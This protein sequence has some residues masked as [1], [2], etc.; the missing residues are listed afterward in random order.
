MAVARDEGVLVAYLQGRVWLCAASRT[1][2]LVK[3]RPM[4]AMPQSLLKPRAQFRTL[5]SL[6]L[7]DEPLAELTM[8]YGFDDGLAAQITQNGNRIRGLLTPI[9]PALE[10]VPGPHLDHPAVLDLLERYPSPAELGSASEKTL[11]NRLTKLAPRMGKS[12]AAKIVRALSEQAVIV[13]G[14]QAATIR[15]VASRPSS[16][17]PC[18]SNARSCQRS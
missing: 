3:P 18:G 12:L 5:R 15:H 9:H 10:R 7:A 2:A 6:R 13:P 4:P 8:L 16:S 14:T 1:C 11:A 17:R